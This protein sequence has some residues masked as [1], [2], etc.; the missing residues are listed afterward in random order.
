MYQVLAFKLISS[1]SYD[2][3]ITRCSCVFSSRKNMEH[4]FSNSKI[5]KKSELFKVN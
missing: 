1:L 2:L 3:L 4:T 5:E